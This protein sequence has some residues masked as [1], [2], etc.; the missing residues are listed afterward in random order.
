MPGQSHAAKKQPDMS[1]DEASRIEQRTLYISLY[2][3]LGI[4]FGSLAYGVY[5]QSDVVILNGIFS[6]LS[7]IGSGLNLIAAKL[8]I[9]REDKR[10]Q[11]GYWHVEPLVHC[12]NGLMMLIIC[13][14]AFLNGIEGLRSG[15]NAV[16]SDQVILFSIVSGFICG[17]VWLYESRMSVRI[18]SQ[19]L[20][21]DSR[22]WLMDFSFSMVTLAGFLALYVLQGPALVFWQRYADNAMVSIM[23]ILLIP[24]PVRV[25]LRNIPEVLLMSKPDDTLAARVQTALLQIKKEYSIA[26]YTSHV[27]KVGRSYFVEVNILASPDFELQRIAQQDKLRERILAACEKN[28]DEVWLSVS[29]TA[30]QRWI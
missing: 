10:F 16:E 29:I 30:D 9:R 15:G 7:L 23:S 5:I 14:Y 4:A 12:V 24:L 22:E 17:G 2:S 6:L 28:L 27:V 25:L 18:G 11:Y 8:V 20:R 1:K 19:I 21:N 13:I 3:V 26:N